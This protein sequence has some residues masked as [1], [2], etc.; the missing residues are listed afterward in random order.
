MPKSKRLRSDDADGNSSSDDNAKNQPKGGG[1]AKA[2]VKVRPPTTAE[3]ARTGAILLSSLAADSEKRWKDLPVQSANLKHASA[4][5]EARGEMAR[6]ADSIFLGH[7]RNQFA[8]P[9][10]ASLSNQE[11]EAQRDSAEDN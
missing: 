11:K 7:L 6:R 3:V 10:A 9:L 4:I 8:A 5:R 2:T 1:C